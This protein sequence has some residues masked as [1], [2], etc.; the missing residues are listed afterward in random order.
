MSIN[1]GLNP[2]SASKSL[3]I[4]LSTEFSTPSAFNNFA[5]LMSLSS[6][7]QYALNRNPASL[8]LRSLLI[9]L[10]TELFF[11]SVCYCLYPICFYFLHFSRTKYGISSSFR[12][13]FL[14]NS[15]AINSTADLTS[16]L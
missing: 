11:H 3:L 13:R 12:F 8:H 16:C 5:F 10:S 4:K 9:K 7:K 6:H 2:A 1:C 14:A 15:C